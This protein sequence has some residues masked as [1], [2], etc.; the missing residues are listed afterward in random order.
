[1]AK[2]ASQAD[3]ERHIVSSAPAA[4]RVAEMMRLVPMVLL[5]DDPRVRDLYVVW[6]ATFDDLPHRVRLITTLH[7][8]WADWSP[9]PERVLRQDAAVELF[10]VNSRDY[11]SS[12]R[13]LGS[14]AT[15]GFL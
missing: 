9:T 12:P 13:R 7:E 2:G 6:Q 10:A 8:T 4:A 1:M 11:T 5:R 14:G 15:A 3:L